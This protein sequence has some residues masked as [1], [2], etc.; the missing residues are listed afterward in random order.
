[1]GLKQFFKENTP[2]AVEKPSVEMTKEE[3]LEFIK[4]FS[5]SLAGVIN[6]QYKV[7]N[8]ANKDAYK[9]NDVVYSCVNILSDNI[10][11]LPLRVYRGDE[12]LP[13]EFTFPNGF[14]I[15]HPHPRMSMNRLNNIASKY[16][17][18]RG[19]FMVYISE[20]PPFSLEPINPKLMKI[21]EE[22][23]FGNILSWKHSNGIIIPYEQVIYEVM[24]DPDGKRALP[25]VEV[26]KL[27]I[28]NDSSNGD[29][30]VITR[31]KIIIGDWDMNITSVDGQTKSVNE[32]EFKCCIS[33]KSLNSILKIHKKI[34]EGD[35]LFKIIDD[36]SLP[37]ITI[38]SETVSYKAYCSK[39]KIF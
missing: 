28:A 17:F 11:E 3:R 2:E 25:P 21:N 39:I 33:K 16:Y 14:S 27:E 9:S 35:V 32:E 30:F 1:M 22:D 7:L 15:Q 6:N 34:G 13:E 18:L 26:L 29:T 10:A 38:T 4:N 5:S 20:E 36:E 24:T 8:L 37:F 19:E 12:L 31:D 23:D